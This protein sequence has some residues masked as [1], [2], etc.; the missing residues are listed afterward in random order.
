MLEKAEINRKQ[1][2]FRFFLR[3]SR[4]SLQYDFCFADF[5]RHHYWTSR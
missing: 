3:P 1:P 2:D 4:T 5:I